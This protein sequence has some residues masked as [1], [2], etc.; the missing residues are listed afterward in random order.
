MAL[1]ADQVECLKGQ[2]HV[3][4]MNVLAQGVRRPL[5][6]SDAYSSPLVGPLAEVE[7]LSADVDGGEAAVTATLDKCVTFFVLASLCDGHEAAQD[8]CTEKGILQLCVRGLDDP[9]PQLRCWAALT[10]SRAV[11]SSGICLRILE[12]LEMVKR[13]LPLLHDTDVEV[14]AAGVCTIG[15][16]ASVLDK[17]PQVFRCRNGLRSGVE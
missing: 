12:H 14:R 17:I 15:A 16:I 10:I 9:Q 7:G 2:G 4:F 6:R 8:V 3:Y 11:A 13:V 5:E 1:S